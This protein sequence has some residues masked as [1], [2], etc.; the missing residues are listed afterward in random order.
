MEKSLDTGDLIYF[1]YDCDKCFTPKDVVLCKMQ[2]FMKRSPNVLNDKEQAE[3][4]AF[5]LRTSE[6]K[7]MVI[8]QYFGFFG[9]NSGT[10]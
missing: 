8:S 7:I 1:N 9:P 5:T 2:K 10:I 3:N 6:A 4:V